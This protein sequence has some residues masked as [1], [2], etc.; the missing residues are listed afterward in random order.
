MKQQSKG[1]YHIAL[2]YNPI[3]KLCSYRLSMSHHNE[4]SM[5]EFQ[6]FFKWLRSGINKGL[7]N[8][9]ITIK[10]KNAVESTLMQGMWRKKSLLHL[11]LENRSSYCICSQGRGRRAWRNRKN[12]RKG[13]YEWYTKISTRIQYQVFKVPLLSLDLVI[14]I[15]KATIPL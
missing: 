4:S 3:V 2:H 6:H 10:I 5:Q 12:A 7:D 1:R 11:K 15:P 9:L 8:N 13:K 14:N